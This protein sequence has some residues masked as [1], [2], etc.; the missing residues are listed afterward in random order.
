MTHEAVPRIKQRKM[1][2]NKTKLKLNPQ[3]LLRRPERFLQD[4]QDFRN[5]QLTFIQHVEPADPPEIN[6]FLQGGTP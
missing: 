6:G 1:Q 3:V 2:T 4:L 5:R